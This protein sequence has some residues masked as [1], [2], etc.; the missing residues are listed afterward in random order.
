ML[1]AVAPLLQACLEYRGVLLQPSKWHF[2]DRLYESHRGA[3]D[4]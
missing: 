1:L 3:A 2:S 4:C